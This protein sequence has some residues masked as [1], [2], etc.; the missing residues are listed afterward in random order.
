MRKKV[1]FLL[2]ALSISMVPST[3]LFAAEDTELD[4]VDTE[5]VEQYAEPETELIPDE[6]AETEE[7]PNLPEDLSPEIPDDTDVEEEAPEEETVG[8]TA[9]EE[10]P[11]LTDGAGETE[12]SEQAMEQNAVTSDSIEADFVKKAFG[13]EDAAV[14][15]KPADSIL[16][17][18]G[19]GAL[20]VEYQ[21]EDEF[22][23]PVSAYKWTVSDTWYSVDAE[24]NSVVLDA[25]TYQFYG[26]TEWLIGANGRGYGGYI[27]DNGLWS[28]YLGISD[29][30]N[31]YASGAGYDG[32]LP[33]AIY[34]GARWTAD[35]V[36]SVKGGLHNYAGNKYYMLR[37]GTILMNGTMRV[38]DSWYE[39]GE[40]GTCVRSYMKN[41]WKQERLGYYVRVD[42]NGNIIRT[43]GFYNIDGN[44]YFLCG[45]SGRRVQGWLSWKGGKYYFDQDTGVQVIGKATIDGVPYYFNPDS[46]NPGKMVNNANVFIDGNRYYF[47]YQDGELITGWITGGADGS[48][49]YY[50]NTDGS[51]KLGWNR[52]ASENRTYYFEPKWGYALQGIQTIDGNTYLFVPGT[53][54]VGRNWVTVN[55]NK[56]YCDPKTAILTIGFA[57][58][59]G[60]QYYFDESGKLVV[61]KENYR[62]DGTL[63]DI[64]AM[65]HYKESELSEVEQLAKERLDEVGWDLRSAYEWCVMD[66]VYLKDAP[67]G[68]VLADYYGEIGLKN[69]YGN[70]YV[71]ASSF[72]HMARL[73]GFDIHFVT[74]Y[75]KSNN[76]YGREPHGW[77]EMDEEDGIFVYDPEYESAKGRNGFRIYYGQPTTW[78]YIDYTRVN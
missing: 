58:I 18:D 30:A 77:C 70:C 41:Y 78:M 66:Y 15:F 3:L 74:G 6:S 25:G 26:N 4:F 38:G 46:E 76:Q 75:I 31:G 28:Y 68:S 63:Y 13:S 24:G 19:Y 17:C 67:E 64:D 43:A 53:D 55:G 7:V 42:E 33:E 71:M 9:P 27:V 72:Y 22:M 14:T 57:E 8:T 5:I 35:N 62:I 51:L 34:H 21:T 47:G 37:N 56:Y 40:D 16:V 45:N 48:H 23:R 61:N 59:N 36:S 11:E 44:T 50:I 52:I 73:L 32:D 65:G 60:R 12:S 10:I 49:K 54:A 1:Y 39:F 29:I 69:H 20:F 2:A